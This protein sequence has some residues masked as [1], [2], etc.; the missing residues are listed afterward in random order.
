MFRYARNGRL[1]HRV[2]RHPSPDDGR[3]KEEHSARQHRHDHAG[4]EPIKTLPLLERTVDQTQA[5][6]GIE[7]PRQLISGFGPERVGGWGI[8]R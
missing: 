7:K 3:E 1:H 6:T 4:V 5:E 8:A 2:R